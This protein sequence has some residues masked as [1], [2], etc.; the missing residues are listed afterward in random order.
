MSNNYREIKS[1]KITTY[2]YLGKFLDIF[3]HQII[4]AI[5]IFSSWL[6]SGLQPQITENTWQP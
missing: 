4:I 5:V 6:T 2:V 3:T 1:T